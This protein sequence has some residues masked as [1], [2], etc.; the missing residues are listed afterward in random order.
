MSPATI[1]G[2]NSSLFS[3]AQRGCSS[4]AHCISLHSKIEKRISTVLKREDCWR[5]RGAIV[6]YNGERLFDPEKLYPQI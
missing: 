6:T 1:T 5:P 2:P 3:S 4:S